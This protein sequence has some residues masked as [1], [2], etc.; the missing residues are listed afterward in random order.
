MPVPCWRILERS[1]CKVRNLN[2]PESSNMEQQG[3]ARRRDI[4]NPSTCASDALILRRQLQ[5]MA[6][7]LA[8]SSDINTSRCALLVHKVCQ[9]HMSSR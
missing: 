2:V 9:A 5:C 1:D 3:H 6:L 8:M 7:G 4:M